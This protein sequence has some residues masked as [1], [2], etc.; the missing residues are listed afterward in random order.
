MTGSV[1]I[2]G[3]AGGVAG[4]LIGGLRGR[5]D[6]RLTDRTPG[7][8]IIAGDLLDPGF[9]REVVSDVAAVVHLAG[10]P[11]PGKPWPLLR[12]SNVDAAVNLF[13]AAVTAGV[14]RILIASSVHAAGGYAD[15]GRT[16]IDPAAAPYP[17]CAYGA[18]KVLVEAL[19]RVYSD[20][21]GLRVLCLRL[22]GVRERPAGRSWL[23]AW[24][25]PPDLVRLVEAALCADVTYGIYHGTSANTPSMWRLDN[26]RRELGYEPREDSAAYP[27]I[28]DDLARDLDPGA[29]PRLGMLHRS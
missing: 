15:A 19:G 5:C 2:T 21:R 10:D 22:G 4:H 13:D 7:P 9:A 20:Q 1:L 23:S 14:P 25:S 11:D 18:A 26:A 24:L 3:A 8:G 12:G 17:C 28:P 29:R 16:G 27:D 6:L